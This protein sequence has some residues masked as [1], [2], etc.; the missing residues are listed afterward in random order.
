MLFRSAGPIAPHVDVVKAGG[1]PALG[2]LGTFSGCIGRLDG[3]VRGRAGGGRG[4]PGCWGDCCCAKAEPLL[5]ATSTAA[6]KAPRTR[7]NGNDRRE[8]VIANPGLLIADKAKPL[9][10]LIRDA[11][12]STNPVRGSAFGDRA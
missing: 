12:D 3:D 11:V 1:G 4:C 5:H 7:E 8:K 6:T 2:K 9:Q 10:A